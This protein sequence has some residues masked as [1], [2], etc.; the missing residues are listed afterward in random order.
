MILHDYKIIGSELVLN[1]VGG[2][3]QTRI[4]LD[5]P[6]FSSVDADENVDKM[7]IGPRLFSTCLI[8]SCSL[9]IF[10]G[11]RLPQKGSQID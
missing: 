7:K 10:L 8:R 2:S 5:H 3:L 4:C 1:F 11:I 6:D 9:E